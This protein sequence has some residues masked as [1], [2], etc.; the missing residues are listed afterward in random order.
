MV[1]K[2]YVDFYKAWT[3]MSQ[4][5]WDAKSRSNYKADVWYSFNRNKIAREMIGDRWKGK[6]VLALGAAF[7]IDAELLEQTPCK[8]FLR[9]DLILSPGIEVI[10]DACD[11][12]FPDESFDAIVCREVAEHVLSDSELFY[13]LRRVL[14]KGGELFI[15]TPN[16]YNTPPDGKS[17]V[18]AYTPQLFLM[19]LERWS[20]SIISKRG[21]VPNIHH[22]LMRLCSEGLTFLEEF[23]ELAKIYDKIKESYYFGS[24]LIVLA[25]K[26]N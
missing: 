17:H 26:A 7:W 14:K 2:E 16:G 6:K 13:E 4:K 15:T 21:N 10:C 23:K 3:E 18:R 20:F 25:R 5:L 8:S 11:M 1:T 9:T 24:E 22:G 19:A 12:Q